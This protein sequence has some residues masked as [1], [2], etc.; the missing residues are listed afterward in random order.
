M[1]TLI[2]KNITT[3]V[4]FRVHATPIILTEPEFEEFIVEELRLKRCPRQKLARTNSKWQ[5]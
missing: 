4:R 3:S 5:K 2:G 1:I